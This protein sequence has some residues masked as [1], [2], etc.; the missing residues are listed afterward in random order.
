[1][2]FPG[3]R[4]WWSSWGYIHGGVHI[5]F[6]DMWMMFMDVIVCM[7]VLPPANDLD[8]EGAMVNCTYNSGQEPQ[9]PVIVE[10]RDCLSSNWTFVHMACWYCIYVGEYQLGCF[11]MQVEPGESLGM[12]IKTVPSLWRLFWLHCTEM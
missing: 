9:C 3:G 12:F 7:P 1:M 6:N 8:D 4:C 11:G 2:H 5:R 10:D